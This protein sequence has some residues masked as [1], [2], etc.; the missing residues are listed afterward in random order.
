MSGWLLS[1]VGGGGGGG[2]LLSVPLYTNLLQ[3]M[4]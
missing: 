2:G 3:F 1:G 4:I